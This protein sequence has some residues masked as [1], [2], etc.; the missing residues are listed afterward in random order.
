MPET[1]RFAR[2][3]E[4]STGLLGSVGPDSN[5]VG[6]YER[7]LAILIGVISDFGVNTASHSPASTTPNWYVR[8]LD[9]VFIASGWVFRLWT[10]RL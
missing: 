7:P 8:P 9:D 4:I 6:V 10:R 2:G 1:P 5:W 3:L